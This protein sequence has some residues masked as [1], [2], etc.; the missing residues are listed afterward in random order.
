[1][2]KMVLLYSFITVFFLFFLYSITVLKPKS[3]IE[4]KGS[5]LS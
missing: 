4:K 5:R 1:M 3:N 2:Y